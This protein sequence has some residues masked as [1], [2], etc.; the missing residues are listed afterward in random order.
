[1]SATK[2]SLCAWQ[3]SGAWLP[4]SNSE[5]D[6]TLSRTRPGEDP[7]ADGRPG[8]AGFESQD[9]CVKQEI[10]FSK[11]ES[12]CFWKHVVTMQTFMQPVLSLCNSELICLCTS[13]FMLLCMPQPFFCLL[14]STEMW[15]EILKGQM[16][17]QSHTEL[18]WCGGGL[19]GWGRVCFS[20]SPASKQKPNL[21]PKNQPFLASDIQFMN[22]YVHLCVSSVIFFKV[23]NSLSLS[24]SVNSCC[25]FD[26]A[27]VCWLEGQQIQYLSG[28]VCREH[29]WGHVYCLLHNGDRG[30]TQ[31]QQRENFRCLPFSVKNPFF[32]PVS[33][34]T[35]TH[36]HRHK[37]KMPS[38]QSREYPL[39]CKR[40]RNDWC[41]Y[42]LKFNWRTH[43]QVI[44]AIY[45]LNTE[46]PPPEENWSNTQLSSFS[47]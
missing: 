45:Q 18:H 14:Q 26:V 37:D 47:F 22:Y 3:K 12:R 42:E 34:H 17:D 7:P 44:G 25:P 2:L 8:K 27:L 40:G 33:A 43:F 36:T 46:T 28:G 16:K 21:F 39:C 11:E 38:N 15:L 41:T 24:F 9:K 35:H 31:R 19:S 13:V 20:S 1:M 30:G 29:S 4:T 23:T 6:E 32:L 10:P 5:T